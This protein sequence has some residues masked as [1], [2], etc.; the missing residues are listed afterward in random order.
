[1]GNNNHNRQLYFDKYIRN[2]KTP[3]EYIEALK[4]SPY[5][6]H[7]RAAERLAVMLNDMIMERE[8]NADTEKHIHSGD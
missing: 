4:K 7:N 1:M 5:R 2:T 3:E 8:K 6:T